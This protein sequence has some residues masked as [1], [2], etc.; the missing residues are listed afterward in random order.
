VNETPRPNVIPAAWFVVALLQQWALWVL[1][2]GPAIVSSAVQNG[3]GLA[4]FLGGAVFLYRAQRSHALTPVEIHRWTDCPATLAM[5]ASLV[6]SA[7]WFGT[8]SGVLPIAGFM[9]VMSSQFV[10]CDEQSLIAASGRSGR[11]GR[12]H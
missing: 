9:S 11:S 1:L 2:P 5:L 8:L 6:G 3:L 4:L 12:R 10:V 7:L